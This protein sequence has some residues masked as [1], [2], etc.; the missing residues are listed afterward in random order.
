MKIIVTADTHYD[1]WDYSGRLLLEAQREFLS[2]VDMLIVAG[3]LTNNPERNWKACLEWLCTFLPAEKIWVMPGNHDYYGFRLDGDPQLQAIAE[4][5]GVNFAQ[6]SVIEADGVRF[7]LCT[8][9][10]DMQLLGTL[11]QSKAFMMRGMND[12]HMIRV[13]TDLS[14]MRLAMPDDTIL[15]HKEHLAWLD[16][17]L[18][19][20]FDG[21]TV[22]VTHHCPHPAATG[23]VDNFTAGFTSDLSWI[24]EKHAPEAWLFGHTHRHLRATVGR[25]EV[26]NISLGYPREVGPGVEG[27]LL[28]RGIVD[29]ETDSLLAPLF[30][31]HASIIRESPSGIRFVVFNDIPDTLKGP[32]DSYLL[33]STCPVVDGFMDA[34]YAT[35]WIGFCQRYGVA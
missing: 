24:I 35:D 14:R 1:I 23:V 20:P 17:E 6:K 3:D 29:T 19:R 5:V 32:F 18:A 15:V 11:D 12:Y 26:R 10:T 16:A 34:A 25:T 28:L 22:V 21:R 7:L 13:P 4:S 30:S 9:W 31:D 27:S 8:L 33:G 2:D